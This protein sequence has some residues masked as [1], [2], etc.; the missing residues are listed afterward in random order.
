MDRMDRR[1]EAKLK[2]APRRRN[3]GRK[4]SGR[5]RRERSRRLSPF[6]D[7]ATRERDAAAPEKIRL[8]PEAE[9][10]DHLPVTLHVG[11]LQ[12]IE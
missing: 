12:V 6:S 8:L 11:A 10:F 7:A 3:F 2:E 4:S 5:L 1:H 9:G